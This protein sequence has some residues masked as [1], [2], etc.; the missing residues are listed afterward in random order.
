MNDAPPAGV[1][2]DCSPLDS[3]P[4]LDGPAGVEVVLASASPSRRAMLAAAGQR[5]QGS[6]AGLPA[7]LW[8]ECR[9]GA[10]DHD[11]DHGGG[12][13]PLGPSCPARAFDY[14]YDDDYDYEWEAERGDGKRNGAHGGHEPGK[15][16][17]IKFRT[18]F[19][20]KNPA[21]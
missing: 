15:D 17:E 21:R 1:P 6:A 16:Q 18:K 14:A 11:H 4:V 2:V 3:A 10:V 20:T 9:V 8:G 5:R 7:L 13:M 12:E 19:K